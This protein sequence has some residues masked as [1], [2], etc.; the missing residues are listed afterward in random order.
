MSSKDDKLLKQS[1]KIA[2]LED[3]LSSKNDKLLKQAEKII[4]HKKKLEK[5]ENNN[6]PKSA[7]KVWRNLSGDIGEIH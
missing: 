6:L 2:E 7:K 4:E 5:I 3:K 1:E